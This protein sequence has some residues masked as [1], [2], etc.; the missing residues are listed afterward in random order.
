M[1]EEPEGDSARVCGACVP[2][3]AR[4]RQRDRAGRE[5]ERGGGGVAGRGAGVYL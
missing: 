3:R 1:Q 5:G 2:A 4:G